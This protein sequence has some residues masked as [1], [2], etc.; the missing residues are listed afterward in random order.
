MVNSDLGL[1]H[2]VGMIQSTIFAQSLSNCTHIV[3]YLVKVKVNF[4]PV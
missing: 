2:I 4:G 3:S 1:C